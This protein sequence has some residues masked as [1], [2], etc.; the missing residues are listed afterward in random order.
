MHLHRLKSK[1]GSKTY[2]SI[3][4]RE[5][6]RDGK[7]VR[8][9]TIAN[10]TNWPPELIAAVEASLKGQQLVAADAI[11][12][13][14]GKN[15]GALFA[16]AHLAKS[17]RLPEALGSSRAGRLALAMA[18][19]RPIKSVSK[20][21]TVAMSKNQAVE[22]LLGVSAFD[23]DDLYGSLD[24]LEKNQNTI[25]DAL[26]K[27][28]GGQCHTLF[29]Y[30]VTS[31]YLEG[32]SNEL[33]K[34]G[35]NRDKK[36]GK[37]QIVIGL[38]K[39]ELGM[40][41]SVQVY[42]GNMLDHKTVSDQIKKLKERFGVKRVVMIGDRG[43]LKQAQ[44]DEIGTQEWNYITALTKPQLESLL[45]L[46]AIQLGLFDEKI[47]EVE[48]DG[49]RLVLRRNPKRAEE[50]GK[51]RQCR[52]DKFLAI[53]KEAN[54]KLSRGP[55]A[56]A[57]KSFQ[58]ISAAVVRY[59]L[60][61]FVNL[62][63]EKRSIEVI[64]DEDKVKSAA[65]LDGCYA[66]VTDLDKKHCSAETVH[67]RYKDLAQVETAFRLMKSSLEVRPLWHRRADRTRGHV[68]VVMLS[69]L[70]L[71]EFQRRIDNLNVSTQAAI[72]ALNNI[73]L[74]EVRIGDGVVV[75]KLPNS[76]RADQAK[77]LKALKLRLPSSV[78]QVA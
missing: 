60:E 30:D 74:T 27:A 17:L 44:I 63:L 50:V 28:R 73:Q 46:G 55:R 67:D 43:M 31:S 59:N 5:S 3:L 11:Q 23:E 34:Y 14:S 53:A 32:Q 25:E 71:E 36:A 33:A 26:F 13:G 69:L 62:R 54:E 64:V 41:V 65:R 42:E 8:K 49:R 56:D 22:E 29:L 68:F 37:K 70:L 58:K 15:F 35:Y 38:L 61:K 40:P 57:Q 7:Q 9:R 20:L 24:W 12:V 1:V 39:D 72:D 48:H 4:L 19:L 10:V 66:L 6:Y 16:F 75:S 47:C 52:L 77:I 18:V 76:P 2:N 78:K 51:N 45:E 21:A